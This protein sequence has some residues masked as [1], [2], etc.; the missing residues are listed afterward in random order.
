MR[1]R[2]RSRVSEVETVLGAGVVA[3]SVKETASKPYCVDVR[4]SSGE[5]TVV[6]A[7]HLELIKWMDD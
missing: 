7:I 5:S 4:G 3:E 1:H 6:V 2:D